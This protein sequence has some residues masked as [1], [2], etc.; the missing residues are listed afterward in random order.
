[1][2]TNHK[3]VNYTLDDFC[4]CL[5]VGVFS[6]GIHMWTSHAYVYSVLRAVLRL[7]CIVARF[8]LYFDQVQNTFGAV[9]HLPISL[10]FFIFCAGL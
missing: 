7:S 8:P 3:P 9:C 10:L 2:Y 4:E 1:M 5:H 6:C